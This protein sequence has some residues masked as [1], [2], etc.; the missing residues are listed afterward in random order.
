MKKIFVVLCLAICMVASVIGNSANADDNRTKSIK[1][2][3]T[4][5]TGTDGQPLIIKGESKDIP[6]RPDEPKALA[7]DDKGR[8]WD[9]E[10]AGWTTKKKNMPSNDN[11]TGAIGKTVVVIRA[12]DHPYFTAFM[13]GFKTIAKEYDLNVKRV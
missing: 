9:Q 2:D 5:L 8:W 1:V 4:K 11:A 7:D 13:N 10:F 6:P 12:G 3:V